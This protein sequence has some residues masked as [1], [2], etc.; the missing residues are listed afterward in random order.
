[1]IVDA[2]VLT[3]V[4]AKRHAFEQSVAENEIASVASLG[5]EAVFLEA[6]LADAVANDVVLD[7]LQREF[8][9]GDSS[10]GLDPIFNAEFFRCDISCHAMPP[11][12]GLG[13]AA[14]ASEL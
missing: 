7:V 12:P 6:V 11:N 9:F 2:A 4:P 14:I 10:E 3:D 5:K 13:F 8:G 1:M